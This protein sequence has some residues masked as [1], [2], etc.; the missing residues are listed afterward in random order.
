MIISL[1]PAAGQDEHDFD[2]VGS[3]R[4][5]D[6]V[7]CADEQDVEFMLPFD[8]DVRDGKARLD[9]CAAF[10]LSMEEFLEKDIF[11]GP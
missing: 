11:I 9:D 2:R 1:V 6:A 8:H 3:V 4:E 5:I 7:T 10:R